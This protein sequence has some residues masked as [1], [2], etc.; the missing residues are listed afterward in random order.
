MCIEH[1]HLSLL[2]P[3]PLLKVT[4]KDEEIQTYRSKENGEMS[5]EF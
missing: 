2:Y 5:T 3:T 4:V 1:M